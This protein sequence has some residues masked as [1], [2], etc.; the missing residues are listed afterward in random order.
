[1]HIRYVPYEPDQRQ[2]LIDFIAADRYPFNG[3]PQPT[4]EQAASWIDSGIYAEWFWL[5]AAS[6]PVDMMHYQDASDIHAEVHLRL[7]TPY[8]G[9]GPGTA[10]LRWL[11]AHLFRTYPVKH[12]IEGW[13][14]VDNIAMRHVFHNCGYVKEAQL[15]RDFPVEDGSYPDKVGYGLL[16]TDWETGATTPIIDG[17]TRRKEHNT[18]VRPESQ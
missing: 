15:C 10:A 1:M 9:Q 7:H 17:L 12:R 14:R 5:L 2:A 11:S 8:R 6:E 18:A 4:K 3:V 16:R 13:T